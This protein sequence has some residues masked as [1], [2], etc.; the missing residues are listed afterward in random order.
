M[1][2]MSRLQKQTGAAVVFARALRLPSGHGYDLTFE[3]F[4]EG[5]LNERAM[6][7][8]IERLIREC[9]TQYLWSYNRYKVPRGVERPK[10]PEKSSET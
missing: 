8:G 4:V 2:L 6:N 5:A 1:T 7:R 9:P 3:R 10:A